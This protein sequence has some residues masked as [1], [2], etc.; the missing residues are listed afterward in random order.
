MQVQV[1]TDN[2]VEGHEEFVT[3]VQATVED[4]LSRFAEHIT[5]VEV[6][7]GDENAQ[8][9]GAN[10]KRC[11]MEARPAGRAPIAVTHT[12]SDIDGAVE[13][14]AKKLQTALGRTLD[15]LSDHKGRTPAGGDP[16]AD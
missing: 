16:H 7:V 13:G 8:K 9:G 15:K 11:V 2:R 1:N 6:H 4:A 10:D 3:G 5:R 12:A 14:A